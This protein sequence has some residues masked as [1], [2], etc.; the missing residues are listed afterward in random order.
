MKETSKLSNEYIIIIYYAEGCQSAKHLFMLFDTPD[1]R[2]FA[3]FILAGFF[4]C[5]CNSV[6]TLS[7]ITNSCQLICTNISF[8]ENLVV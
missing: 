8:P 4:S 6:M 7:V 1:T 3:L 2:S 5:L